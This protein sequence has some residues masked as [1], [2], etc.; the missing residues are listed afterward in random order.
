[1][2]CSQHWYRATADTSGGL[3]SLIFFLCQNTETPNL[4]YFLS[5]PAV[6][7]R[8]KAC[9]SPPTVCHFAREAT[10][11]QRRAETDQPSDSF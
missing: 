8:A 1:M 5:L 10:T 6:A 2:L 4:S 9:V 11:S 3:A 7:E